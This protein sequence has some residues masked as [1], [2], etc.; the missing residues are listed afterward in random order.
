M[1]TTSFDIRPAIDADRPRLLA[2]TAELQAYERRME[3]NRC[4]PEE[5]TTAHLDLILA[6][7]SKNDG[8]AFT[9]VKGSEVLG[10]AVCAIEN[11]EI[12]TLQAYRRIGVISDVV[13]AE[14]RRG[15][16]VGAAL[17]RAC[18]THVASLGVLRVEI[19]VL[20]AN[21]AA[22][23]AYEACG[24]LPAD[25]TMARHLGGPLAAGGAPQKRGR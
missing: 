7:S 10:Y 5:M 16:G 15:Q 24:Y 17:I 20:Y 25:M 18:E 21:D 19:G 22:R 13:V 4:L 2:L 6:W 14:S 12:Y 3:P 23:A 9:A 11:A 8:A 1:P